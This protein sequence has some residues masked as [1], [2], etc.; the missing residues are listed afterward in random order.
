VLERIVA[1]VLFFLAYMA[2][3]LAISL[4]AAQFVCWGLSHMHVGTGLVGPYLVLA[5][6]S[7]TVSSAAA[8][9]ARRK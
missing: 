4:I 9:S 5:G 2:M 6:L 1:F 3:S 7:M 8:A